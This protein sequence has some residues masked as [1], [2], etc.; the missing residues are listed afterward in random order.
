MVGKYCRNQAQPAVAAVGNYKEQSNNVHLIFSPSYPRP[1]AG[2]W[3]PSGE[4]LSAATTTTIYIYTLAPTPEIFKTAPFKA[5]HLYLFKST[6]VKLYLGQYG[7]SFDWL[8]L[9]VYG[10]IFLLLYL[11]QPSSIKLCV[12]ARS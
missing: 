6:P 11:A 8:C 12:S 10:N 7:S 1:P 3:L 2:D 9:A 4:L 5:L